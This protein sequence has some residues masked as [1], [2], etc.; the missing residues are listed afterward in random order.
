MRRHSMVNKNS[1]IK[2]ILYIPV[3]FFKRIITRESI[4][5][6]AVFFS[7]SALLLTLRYMYTT[8]QNP[9]LARKALC[10]FIAYT[11]FMDAAAIIWSAI[12]TA[13]RWKVEGF[14]FS[15]KLG[16]DKEEE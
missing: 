8:L 7:I 13:K 4:V 6:S 11:L 12:D 1:V 15:M 5:G 16:S 14:S 3:W 2:R 9:E 10:I